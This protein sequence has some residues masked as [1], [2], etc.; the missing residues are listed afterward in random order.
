MDNEALYD[1]C[2]KSLKIK[3]PEYKHLNHIISGCM[4][5]LTTGFRFPGP[6]NQDLRKLAV[7]MVPFPRL[8]FF[9]PGYAPLTNPDDMQYV[10]L[11][12]PE[13][14]QQMFE[15]RNMLAA[16][17]PK[18]GR[19]MTLAAMFRGEL[20]MQEIEEQMINM[21]NKNSSYFVEWIPNNVK[22]GV[23][24]IPPK[25]VEKSVTFTCNSTSIQEL[26]KRIDEQFEAMFSKQAFLHWYTGEG[27]DQQ[28]FSDAQANLK[29]VIEEY[30][31]YQEI[32]IDDADDD[33]ADFDGDDDDYE[34]GGDEDG[35]DVGD[36]DDDDDVDD[37]GGDDEDAGEEDDDGEGDEE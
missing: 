1:I 10:K 29:E 33:D 19:Y 16:C 28:Q 31:K 32:G 5:G 4:S 24:N 34:A 9:M 15:P 23:C 11:E 30:Q 27:M 35:D 2:F 25:D 36:D 14:A 18:S 37:D 17:D 12:V 20:S 6:L 26:L 7:N 3:S 21:Q 22:T 13:L 8:H